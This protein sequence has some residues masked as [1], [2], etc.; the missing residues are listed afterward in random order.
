MRSGKFTIWSCGVFLSVLYPAFEYE[1]TSMEAEA[2][3][4]CFAAGGK[5]VVI[6]DGKRFTREITGT[7]MKMRSRISGIRAFL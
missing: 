2:E 4:F 7:R 5:T 3:G 1:Q 6:P